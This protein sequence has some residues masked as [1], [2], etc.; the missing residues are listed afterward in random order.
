M[1]AWVMMTSPGAARGQFQRHQTNKKLANAFSTGR[2]WSPPGRAIEPVKDFWNIAA[3]ISRQPKK[4]LG[5]VAAENSFPAL[6]RA[7]LVLDISNQLT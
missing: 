7:S 2:S 6:G 3:S 4:E 5:Q 1:L